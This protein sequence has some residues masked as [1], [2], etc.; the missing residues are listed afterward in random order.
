[1]SAVASQSALLMFEHIFYAHSWPCPNYD[2]YGVSSAIWFQHASN[3]H[4]DVC[5][6]VCVCACV[7]VCVSGVVW[8]HQERL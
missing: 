7:C 1:M 4:G 6:C 2:G 5:M 8:T 3:E